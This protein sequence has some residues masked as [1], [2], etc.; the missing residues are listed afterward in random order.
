MNGEDCSYV[1]LQPDILIEGLDKL[2][3]KS[4]VESS[5]KKGLLFIEQAKVLWEDEKSYKFYTSVLLSV[6]L[7]AK[8]DDNKFFIP[9]LRLEYDTNEPTT[10]SNSLIVTFSIRLIP[11]H[12]QCEFV[13]HFK[14]YAYGDC[15]ITFNPDCSWYNVVRFKCERRGIIYNFVIRFR[16]DYI[17]IFIESSEDAPQPPTE[18]YSCLKRACADVLMKISKEYSGLQYKFGVVCP[19][20]DSDA[21]HFVTFSLLTTSHEECD[22]CNTCKSHTL[23]SLHPAINWIE[24]VFIGGYSAGVLLDGKFKCVYVFVPM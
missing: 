18:I 19:K 6:G 2:Y 5:F 12:K 10:H 24:S 7:M 9:S 21:P 15:N 8:V 13:S 1:I 16:S 23:S 17:E 4:S 3:S 22:K 11:F 14:E 20:S